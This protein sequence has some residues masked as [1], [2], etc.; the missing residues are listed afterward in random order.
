[1]AD[2]LLDDHCHLLGRGRG[3]DELDRFHEP[4]QTR[5]SV[6]LV[7]RNHLRLV[8]AGEGFEPV[9]FQ[10]AA[11]PDRQR[12]VH[13]VDQRLEIA[14][15]LLRQVR[16]LKRVGDLVVGE[17]R[18]GDLVEAVVFH[19]GVEHV[20]GHDRQGRDVDRD[21]G[22]RVAAEPRLDRLANE[23]QP[24]GLASETAAADATERRLQ[25]EGSGVE[26]GQVL[27]CKAA[28]AHPAMIAVRARRTAIRSKM[29]LRFGNARCPQRI[30]WG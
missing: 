23:H 24:L 4:P 7:V 9:V 11:R 14:D 19:E 30:P 3:V 13:L 2:R 22:E 26:L 25:L 12:R 27:G 1:M 16:L 5:G 10:Q 21:P 18:V 8:D 6:R 28:V 29:E 17:L 15:D 20:S